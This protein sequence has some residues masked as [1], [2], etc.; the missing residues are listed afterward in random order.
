MNLLL[1]THALLW[2]ATND[3]RLSL[4]AQLFI[5]DPTNNV[6]VSPTSYWELAIK[7]TIGKLPLVVPFETF[8]RTAVDESQLV[9]LPILTAHATRLI[10]LPLHHRDPFDRMLV[11]QALVED[12]AIL[13]CDTALDAYGVQR[14]W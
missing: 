5:E 7:V 2:F 8:I 11:A 12:L 6:F 3:S 14:I 10:T 1:D 4:K 13:S 9:V